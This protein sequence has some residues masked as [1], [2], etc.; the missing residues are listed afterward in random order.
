MA[1]HIQNYFGVRAQGGFAQTLFKDLSV[2]A[3]TTHSV[4]SRLPS[5]LRLKGVLNSTKKTAKIDGKAIT[6]GLYSAHSLYLGFV[7]LNW[8]N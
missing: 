4:F 8:G 3:K 6:M 1:F 5:H 2:G 7:Q